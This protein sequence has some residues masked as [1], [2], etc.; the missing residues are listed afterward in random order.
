MAKA[1]AAGIKL[2]FLEKAHDPPL[3]GKRMGG[4]GQ[5]GD[6]NIGGFYRKDGKYTPLLEGTTNQKIEKEKKS[7]HG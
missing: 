2:F 4:S 6:K 3:G 7:C 5:K 1:P